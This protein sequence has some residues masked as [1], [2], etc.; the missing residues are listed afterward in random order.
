MRRFLLPSATLLLLLYSAAAVV[1]AHEPR[2]VFADVAASEPSFEEAR[3]LLAAGEYDQAK[4]SALVVLASSPYATEGYQVMREIAIAED[5][6]PARLRW[7]KWL[8]WSYRAAGDKKA[9]EE[10]EAELDELWADWNL[11]G[12]LLDEWI[13]ATADTA[14]KAGGKKQYRLAGHLMDKLLELDPAN[15]KLQK[16]FEKLADK[17]GQ[18]LSG[19]AFVAAK[20][21]KKSA[22]WI[23]KES[24]KH[25]D[26]ENRFERKTEYYI[27]E[28]NMDYVFFETLCAAMDQIHLFYKEVFDYQKKAPRATLAVHRKRS[29]FD[30]YT[31]ELGAPAIPSESVGGFW[32]SGRKTVNAYDRSYGDP[33]KTRDDLW[34]TLFH[35][36]S[37]QF[38]SL[39]MEKNERKRIWTPAWLNEGTASYFEGCRIK[40]DGTI[41]KNDIAEGRLRSWWFLENSDRQK[42]L[43]QLVA[44]IR[45]TGPDHTGLLSYEG[46]YYSYGWSFVYFLLN[47]EEND[48]RVYAP[49][50]TPGQGIPTE[51]KA[52][53][54]AG[55]LVYRQAYL[56][57][58]EHFSKVGNKDNDQ[59][60]PMEMAKKFFI[61]DIGDPDVPNWDALEAR[62][63]KFTTSLYRELEAGWEFADV[64]QARC[65]GYLLAEDWERA[66]IT[67]EQA[68]DKRPGDAETYRL[69][70]EA[71]YG[72]EREADALYWMLRHWEEIWKTG[73]E[74]AVLEIEEWLTD[75]GGKDL[76]NNYCV[77]TRETMA[78]IED[79]MEEALAMGQPVMAT[80][81]AS[82]AMMAF[83]CEFPELLAS[84]EEMT[85]VSGQDLRMWQA[86]FDKGSDGDRKMR[87]ND[88]SLIDAVLYQ[89]DGVLI[90]DPAGRESPGYERCEAGV[91]ASLAPP[92]A[93]RGKV[94]VDGNAGRLMLGMSTSGSPQAEI[95]FY[96][97][98]QD[99][100][101]VAV[102]L[103]STQVDS[104]L[105]VAI[106]R[107][108]RIND[109]FVGDS[110]EFTFEIHFHGEDRATMT[111]N[112]ETFELSDKL[113]DRVLTGGIAL[114]STEDTAVLFSDVEVRPNKAF[115]PVA[116]KESDGDS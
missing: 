41:V 70:A 96:M 92:F 49:P 89:E 61:E 24:A 91:L 107:R 37:H 39:L 78:A 27:I 81:F 29:D 69:L 64:L 99:N 100:A 1:E 35:E 109:Q 105:G 36:A 9:L 84:A 73:E 116:A 51:Y 54:R 67:A 111:V 65:R 10:L 106:P 63:R 90:Y 112:E 87:M 58:L 43:E 44:H 26:W 110:P 8:Y 83:D 88:G 2:S 30:R 5:D 53:R 68:D 98:G 17:A 94:A 76:V 113:I 59:Y 101:N 71:N 4:E 115:W 66:R 15:P 40:S 3:R 6:L 11:D 97:D 75:H 25:E 47:Y 86:A 45:N 50:I 77:K 57:Y 95:A 48:R 38:T 102:S 18:E 23:A 80:M 103:L 62:W 104:Q 79:S 14:R 28:S 34:N 31:Q 55:K 13:Q 20:V 33:N 19:G 56:D 42:S 72:A 46:D 22:K 114:A 21:R 60:Y 7:S 93:V 32:M 85:E 74:E 12:V 52:V 108:R 82:H 16:E